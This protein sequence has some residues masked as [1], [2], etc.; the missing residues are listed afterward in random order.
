MSSLSIW[1][2]GENA[3]DAEA[4]RALRWRMTLT[5][6]QEFQIF[7]SLLQGAAAANSEKGLDGS[8]LAAK[9]VLATREVVQFLKTAVPEETLDKQWAEPK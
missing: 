6:E 5:K 3:F 4:Y 2:R 7:C 1:S 9:V 8:K